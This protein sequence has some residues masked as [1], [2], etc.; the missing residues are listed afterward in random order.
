MKK[1]LALG[2]MVFFLAGIASAQVTDQNFPRTEKNHP[3]QVKKMYWP[4]EDD[5]LPLVKQ[6]ENDTS[7]TYYFP[8]F[9]EMW[10]WC[11]PYDATGQDSTDAYIILQVQSLDLTTAAGNSGTGW[12][13]VDSTVIATAD[14]LAGKWDE[15]EIVP[16]AAKYRVV[17]DG[18][19]GLDDNTGVTFPVWIIF[20]Q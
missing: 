10:M 17:L 7:S 16:P 12:V 13:S 4:A 3:I 19:A 6:T 5:K 18:I 9:S 11:K 14:S 20:K 2:L 1:I 8:D 15:W